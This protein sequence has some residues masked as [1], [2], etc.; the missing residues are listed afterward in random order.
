ML[1]GRVG[2]VVRRAQDCEAL[3]ND[4]SR[5]Q[6]VAPQPAGQLEAETKKVVVDHIVG[7]RSVEGPDQLPGDPRLVRND[8][9]ATNGATDLPI[10]MVDLKRNQLAPQ[11][12]AQ[13]DKLALNVA[14]QEQRAVDI[15]AVSELFDLA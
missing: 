8:H 10:G 14:A 3:H 15:A 2:Q 11:L 7:V 5:R 4:L 1:L 12:T 13:V 9:P 6:L